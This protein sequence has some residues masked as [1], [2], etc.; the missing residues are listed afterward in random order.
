MPAERY[1][2]PHLFHE[3]G[4]IELEGTEFHHLANV[5][6]TR[7]GDTV[8]IVNGQGQ[9]A[10][11]VIGT[12]A[13]KH[14]ILSV[15]SITTQTRNTKQPLILVQAIP[16]MNRLEL[17]LEK[18]TELGADEI[19]LLPAA[20]IEKKELT[21]HQL[22]RIEAL[23][24]AAMKQCGR[25]WLPLLKVVAPIKKWKSLPHTVFFGDTDVEAP[26]F[27][28]GWLLAMPQKGALFCVG[29]ERGFSKEEVDSLKLLGAHGVKLHQ[30]TLRT[31]T[32]AF[33]ALSLMSHWLLT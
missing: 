30:N 32:A 3:G 23:L 12:I 5:M 9:L 7:Q 20:Y 13:K 24:I 4:L 8:E 28:N 1:Y 21:E 27:S 15:S 26:L 22:Q 33:A 14:A 10:Q 29:P 17:I 6:R 2:S 16:R 18:S 31:E 11:A 25:L 19:W